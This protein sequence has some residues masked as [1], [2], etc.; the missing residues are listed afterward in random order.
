M[1]PAK[2]NPSIEER[3]Y[4]ASDCGD[5]GFQLQRND[6]LSIYP[7]DQAAIEACIRDALN[8]DLYA[9][10]QLVMAGSDPLVCRTLE[11]PK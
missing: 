6:E 4:F 10:Q 8:G 11:L 2:K 7:D 1:K 5:R 3:P 9:L